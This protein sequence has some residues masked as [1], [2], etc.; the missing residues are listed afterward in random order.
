MIMI[1]RTT[2]VRNETNR[3][4]EDFISTEMLHKIEEAC[5]VPR[6]TLFNEYLLYY[7]TQQLKA[8]RKSCGLTQ[9]AL[10]KLL[11]VSVT[12]IKRWERKENRPP[13]K[14]WQSTIKLFQ[15]LKLSATSDK[16][17][18]LSFSDSEDSSKRV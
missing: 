2:L 1:D 9:P 8:D 18:C 7:E 12:T 15:A 10:A 11:N 5:S 6:Y 13:R 14:M 3:I 16:S 17:L 4:S